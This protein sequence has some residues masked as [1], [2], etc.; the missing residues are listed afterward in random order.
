[1]NNVNAVAAFGKTVYSVDENHP[2]LIIDNSALNTNGNSQAIYNGLWPYA[3]LVETL[4]E[5]WYPVSFGLNSN[6][7]GSVANETQYT[8]NTAQSYNHWHHESAMVLELNSGKNNNPNIQPSF[9][10]MQSMYNQVINETSFTPRIVLWY[11]YV[12]T[13]YG[14]ISMS[15]FINLVTLINPSGVCRV[16]GQ[17]N[18]TTTQCEG[19]DTHTITKYCNGKQISDVDNGPSASCGATCQQLNNCQP[20]PTPVPSTPTPTPFHLGC[21]DMRCT[22]VAGEGSDTCNP[23]VT[24]TCVTPTPTPIL[25]NI[26]TITPTPTLPITVPNSPQAT[27]QPVYGDINHDGKVDILDY[28]V[29][30]ECY[31]EKYHSS[32]CPAGTSPDLDNDGVVDGVDYVILVGIINKEGN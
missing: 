19:T 29:L 27:R 15:Q 11:S 20:T 13:T 5:D 16:Q 28:N 22:K 7:T 4:G 8:V 12:P 23:N 26:P 18:V 25:T 3:Q 31:G 32:T 6:L 24:N 21:I 10:Q 30:I 1:P 17:P 2:T 9:S 14:T